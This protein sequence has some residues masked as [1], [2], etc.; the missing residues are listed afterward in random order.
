ML[1]VV[2][3]RMVAATAPHVEAVAPLAQPSGRAAG[4]G[5]GWSGGA[6]RAA[7]RVRAERLWPLLHCLSRSVVRHA[8]GCVS[9]TRNQ[10][11][12]HDRPSM[13]EA[14]PLQARCVCSKAFL[15]GAQR[16]GQW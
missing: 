16:G 14:K 10:S 7:L 13:T 8:V 9:S 4:R 11:I 5:P 1:Q 12:C 2:V 3:V 6:G 15:L